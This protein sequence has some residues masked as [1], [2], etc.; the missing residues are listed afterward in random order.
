MR[1]VSESEFVIG[2]KGNPVEPPALKRRVV[3]IGSSKYRLGIGGLHSSEESQAHFAG[4][5]QTILDVDVASYYPSI[6]LQCG[7]YP[8]HM[9]ASFLHVYKQIVDSRL[10][11][12]KEQQRL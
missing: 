7:L 1:E 5:D 4:S 3:E 10:A 2:E 9:G 11:A 8:E 6:I 12:K